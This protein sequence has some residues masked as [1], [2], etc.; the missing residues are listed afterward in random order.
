MNKIKIKCLS[1]LSKG[2][3]MSSS[4]NYSKQIWQWRNISFLAA[5]QHLYAGVIST[6]ISILIKLLA[7]YVWSRCSAFVKV[8]AGC[9]GCDRTLKD[10]LGHFLSTPAHG[11]NERGMAS[12]RDKYL[13]GTNQPVR[14]IIRAT[15]P[16]KWQHDWSVDD[17]L[18]CLCCKQESMCRHP[19]C[20]SS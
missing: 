19:L 4:L 12:L 5:V 20:Q 13:R 16:P 17:I 3:K 14:A 2:N 7:L 9:S 6:V 10:S 15:E 11:P 18:F 1:V 8:F